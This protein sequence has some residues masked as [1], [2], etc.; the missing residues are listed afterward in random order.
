MGQEVMTK[1]SVWLKLRK[2][3]TLRF[4]NKD[5]EGRLA[6]IL[7]TMILV[8]LLG[9]LIILVMDLVWGDK[10]LAVFLVLGNLLQLIPL[11]LLFRGNLFAS[12]FVT[13]AIYIGFT[14]IFATIGQGIR[15]Y[16]IMIYPA[17]IMF[18]SLTNQ[19]RGLIVSTLL[20][21]LGLAWLI[22]GEMYGWFIIKNVNALNIFDLILTFLLIIVSAITVHLLVSNLEYKHIQT[23]AELVQRLNAEKALR[24][25]EQNLQALIEN[26]DG[27]IWSVDAQYRL[28][29]G[30][31]LYHKNVSAA[32]GREVKAGENLLSLNLPQPAIEE[33]RNYYD[34]ALQG[35]KFSIEIRTRFAPNMFDMEYRFSP[36]KD[37]NGKIEGVTVFGRDITERKRA[38]EAL[39]ES[40]EDFQRYFNMSTVG[41]AVT[42]SEKDWIE[43]NDRLCQILGYSKEE[44]KKLTW[45]ELT[46][47]D[48]LDVNLEL[49]NK[50]EEGKIDSYQ[51]DKR[52]IRKDKSI[53]YTT[54]YAAC[55]R[56]PTGKLRHLLTSVVDVTEQ[57]LAEKALKENEAIFSSFLENSPV[58]VFFKDKNVR[59]IRLS[60]NYE[61]MLGMS[62]N[63]LLGK[64]MD[65]L[66][67]SDLAKSM[68][69]DDLQI[70]NEGQ[71]VDIVEEFN[72][73][74]Y[75][76]TK[77]PIYK[78]GKPEMLAGFTLDITDRKLAET[79]VRES[80]ERFRQLI[81][82]APDAIFGIG[83]NGKI[84]FAN[85][86]A[87]KL[88]GYSAE[89]LI[90]N[91]VDMFVPQCWKG[92]HANALGRY[93]AQPD[94]HQMGVPADP[95]AI[96]KDGTEIPVDIKFGYSRT[97]SGMLVIA[98]MR[99]IT[100]RKNAET[101]LRG[102]NTQLETQ[103]KQIQ[104]L[105]L[106]LHEQSV[107][108]PLT[109]LYNRRYLTEYIE[110]EMVRAKRETRQLSVIVSDIDHFKIINDTFGHQVGDKFLIEIAS[111]MNKHARSSDIV[112]RY[113]GEE[114]LLVL[115][116]TT[117][118]SAHKRAEELRQMCAE[119]LIPHEGKELRVT[120]SFG[121]ATYPDHGKEA[122]TII[123]KADQAMYKS[124][125]S[126][127]NLVTAWDESC[128]KIQESTAQ[129]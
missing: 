43:V 3:Y 78:D 62:I 24:T 95:I 121:V 128:A 26:S 83:Q 50:M 31:S 94:S 2:W 14:T 28:V 105:Q 70:M 73:R 86:A 56:S 27:S 108:D 41:M 39:R 113:G 64:T 29:I 109:G 102:A 47:P 19:R 114:F 125:N 40:H 55:H 91:S 106:I 38:E 118:N 60:K 51:M 21:L 4:P 75:E 8:Y 12:S 66:F 99:D 120:M 65:E 61:Q 74:I 17:V 15:D 57:K 103:M 122:D 7:L 79:A 45:A 23:R 13:A 54:I 9:S 59:S 98:Y 52:Y 11:V 93:I 44:L 116:G 71:R 5:D 87:T 33:W 76:T 100:E 18:A 123:I 32:I 101:Q 82:S 53:V 129:L 25:N 127:R 22:L 36:I 80:E 115:P 85:T 124:K 96:H 6:R 1:Q 30:N 107:R 49:F 67:P 117:I 72:G 35:E 90:G 16:V 111:L 81:T 112:C 69:A 126:G 92:E 68:V 48:D 104:G 88:L 10:S 63:E 58:Y 34:R 110:R 119:V 84:V 42:N 37:E 46:H 20:T 77:F 89:E 97:S